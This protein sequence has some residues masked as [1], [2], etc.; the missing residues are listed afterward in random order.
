MNVVGLSGSLRA[1]SY[2]TATL[3]QALVFAARAGATVE[4]MNLK[5]LDIPMYDEDTAASPSDD[6]ERLRET[7]AGAD[8]IVI[9]SPEYNYS[10]PGGLK[11]L[12][13]WISRPRSVL[14]GKVAAIMGASGGPFGT[15]RMQAHLRTI[16]T[17]LDVLVLPQP[18][19]FIRN[20]REAFNPD[21]TLRDKKLEEQVRLLVH[22][23]M[24]LADAVR[25]QHEA[26]LV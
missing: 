1:G 26:A 13:D 17:A 11:N 12:I 24:T 18:Q 10:V 20:A 14:G 22:N 15:I 3:R 8:L 5:G 6:V 19:V 4:E 16:L 9:A 7:T 21:G 23:S 2:N 25:R